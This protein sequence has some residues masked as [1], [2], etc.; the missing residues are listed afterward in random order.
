MFYLEILKTII[1]NYLSNNYLQL[2]FRQLSP[3]MFQTII[4][5]YVLLGNIKDFY[6]RLFVKQL[7]PIMFQTIISDYVLL[8]KIKD[9][10][11]RPPS[12]CPFRSAGHPQLLSFHCQIKI[13]T[14]KFHQIISER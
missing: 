10:Y 12:F 2:C 11:L 5:D 14:N 7:S 3:I 6:L 1:S 9:N 8:G 13:N 4:S